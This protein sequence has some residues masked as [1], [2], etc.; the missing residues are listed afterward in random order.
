MSW[1]KIKSG[2][3]GFKSAFSAVLAVL[4]SVLSSLFSFLP[5]NAFQLTNANV[6]KATGFSIQG[7]TGLYADQ[8]NTANNGIKAMFHPGNVNNSTDFLLSLQHQEIPAN[9]I[10][11]V[12]MSVSGA[13]TNYSPICFTGGWNH[14]V[15][16]CDING[17]NG[18]YTISALFYA[19]GARTSTVFW[20]WVYNPNI[21]L[22]NG[23]NIYVSIT[24]PSYAI[25]SE[26][27]S[28]TDISAIKSDLSGILDALKSPTG[29]EWLDNINGKLYNIQ[30]YTQW[31]NADIYA[32]RGL[33][34][35]IKAQSDTGVSERLDRQW[36]Q[37]Q[38]DRSDY[39]DAQT[40]SQD[41]ASDATDQTETATAN[42][43]TIIGSLVSDIKDTPASNCQLPVND[44]GANGVLDLG[45]LDL[46]QLPTE[47][48]NTI[49]II[50][51]IVVTLACFWLSYSLLRTIIDFLESMSTASAMSGK[52]GV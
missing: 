47:F 6:V 23:N 4:L 37:E 10:Y 13:N 15:L 14:D 31:T 41:S 27:L 34:E 1:K 49:T 2:F 32:I 51:S 5:A 39:E 11:S 16:D 36:N 50:T 9:S 40:D 42:L 26:P 43:T 29:D 30:Q 46:C 24:S 12:T 21:T 28:S 18:N 19:T 17:D 33:L 3:K 38:Q 25:V 35:D 7:N 44:M 8:I 45:T 20:Y 22:S 48:R 52:G